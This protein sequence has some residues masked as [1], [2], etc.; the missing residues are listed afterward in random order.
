[1]LTLRTTTKFRKDY[2]RM[3]KQGKNMTL[4]QTVIDDLLA[5]KVLEKYLDHEA[6]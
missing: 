1:M 3:K 2:K 5:E 6:V 4:L